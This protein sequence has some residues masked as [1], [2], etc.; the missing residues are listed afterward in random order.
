MVYSSTLPS[1][2]DKHLAEFRA[3][4]P[5][6]D[7]PWPNLDFQIASPCRADLSCRSRRRRKPG[8]GGST[9]N[10]FPRKESSMKTKPEFKNRLCGQFKNLLAVQAGVLMLCLAATS[11]PA[12]TYTILHS[13]SG[14]DGANPQGDLVLSGTTLYGTTCNGG[15]SNCG[16]VFR[17]STDGTGYTVLKH[18]SGTDGANPW[19][20]LTLSGGTL[21]GATRYGGPA[22]IGSGSGYGELFKLNPDGS[23]FAVLSSSPVTMVLTHSGCRW[24]LATLF[25]EPL[26]PGAAVAAT[27]RYSK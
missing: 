26:N 3:C 25:M 17:I 7:F 20:G 27:A 22:Y 12:Q 1:A 16:T 4:Y 23:G 24:C 5:T 2:G 6:S 14:S 21:Y 10:G 13:F 19:V 11:S 9:F 8:E 15:N 18:F